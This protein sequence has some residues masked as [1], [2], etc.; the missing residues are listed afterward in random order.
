MFLRT[1][2]AA[3]GHRGGRPRRQPLRVGDPT[4]PARMTTSAVDICGIAPSP[5]TASGHAVQRISMRGRNALNSCMSGRARRPRLLRR[6][7]LGCRAHPRHRSSPVRSLLGRQASAAGLGTSCTS[8]M[9]ST[10]LGV[11]P[12]SSPPQASKPTACRTGWPQDCPSMLM[13]GSASHRLSVRIALVNWWSYGDSNPRPLACHE[14]PASSLT[15]PYG[16]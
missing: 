10:T 9:P 2:R 14:S 11:G 16:A 12:S 1:R 8:A 5:N 6:N 13:R 7:C 15:R 4:C 3:C